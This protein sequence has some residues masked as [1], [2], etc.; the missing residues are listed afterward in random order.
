MSGSYQQLLQKYNQLLAL[1]V[2][3]PG[4][5]QNLSS[6]LAFGNTTTNSAIFQVGTEKT[7]IARDIIEIQNNTFEAQVFP[8]AIYTR[9]LDG[10]KGITLFAFGTPTIT[11]ANVTSCQLFSDELRF[12]SGFPYSTAGISIVGTGLNI[13]TNGTLTFEDLGGSDGQFL[14]QN[15]LGNAVWDNIPIIKSSSVVIPAPDITGTISFGFTFA[16]APIVTISQQSSGTIVGLS[17]ISSTTTGFTWNST[18]SG[19][20]KINWIATL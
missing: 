19:V 13:K 2:N 17:V 3:N 4:G 1:I 6:V 18:T 9:T 5:F 8:D 14:K 7:T 10:S 16:S 15:S 11:V 20:G 12:H